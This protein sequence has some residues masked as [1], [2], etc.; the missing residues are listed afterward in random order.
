MLVHACAVSLSPRQD[1][2]LLLM[3]WKPLARPSRLY[4]ALFS[5]ERSRAI[6]RD[7]VR[8]AQR[9]IMV[10]RRSNSDAHLRRC[11]AE[12]GSAASLQP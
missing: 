4:R 7:T 9:E 1:K 12:T 6:F 5:T 8:F 10:E 3:T 2:A 11:I